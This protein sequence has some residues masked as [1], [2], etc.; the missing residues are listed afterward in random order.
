MNREDLG[1]SM[2]DSSC[3]IN[4]L[5]YA[6][7]T[8]CESLSAAWQHLL[9]LVQC[10]FQW[11]QLDAKVPKC[12]AISIQASTGRVVDPKLSLDNENIPSVGFQPFK[13]LGMIIITTTNI[14]E[15]KLSLMKFPE[16]MLVSVD[17]APVNGIRNFN[18]SD[19]AFS[20]GKPA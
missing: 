3:S 16:R 17:K 20:G 14:I 6:D 5:I 7:D 13:F 9:D 11:S 18:L 4:Q 19:M 8:C 2:P 1:F 12:C 15:A 10:W